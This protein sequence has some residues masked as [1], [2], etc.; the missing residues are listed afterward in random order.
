MAD[1]P[2]W[3]DAD[4]P[5]PE[6]EK[7]AGY[8]IGWHEGRLAGGIRHD[9]HHR[10]HS[11]GEDHVF[12]LLDR[13]GFFAG[14][15]PVLDVGCGPSPHVGSHLNT[16]A[17][18]QEVYFLDVDPTMLKLHRA[19]SHEFQHAELGRVARREY[20]LLGD[21]LDEPYLLTDKAVLVHRTLPR[22]R[23]G[24]HA[25]APGTPEAVRLTLESLLS[26]RPH[27]LALYLDG[28]HDLHCPEHP[29]RVRGALDALGAK[30]RVVEGV[31]SA[32]FTP[33]EGGTLLYLTP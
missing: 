20:W 29:A 21:A 1:T 14:N 23:T 3:N 27:R 12:T 26:A 22:S 16:H 25:L 9:Y 8:V 31:A 10:A 2:S 17:G 6:D 5:T 7:L 19:L 32:D 28:G 24:P 11:I 30:Y 4:R 13:E 15:A 18:E 33:R